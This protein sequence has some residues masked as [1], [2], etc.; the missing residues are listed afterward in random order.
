MV[1]EMTGVSRNA[2][3]PCGS[4]IKYKLCCLPIEADGVGG[5]AA[6]HEIRMIDA[7]GRGCDWRILERVGPEETA[8]GELVEHLCNGERFEVQAPDGWLRS[9]K[10]IPMLLALEVLPPQLYEWAIQQSLGGVSDEDMTPFGLEVARVLLLAGT[11]AD[12]VGDLRAPR[13]VGLKRI[14]PHRRQQAA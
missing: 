10:P 6:V 7:T 13:R 12:L 1:A 3:C 14:L 5:K 11:V 2:P 9:G 4:G 8:S